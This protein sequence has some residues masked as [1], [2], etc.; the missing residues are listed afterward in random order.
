M[1][2]QIEQE[3]FKSCAE[4]PA[5]K[6]FKQKTLR[7]HRKLEQKFMQMRMAKKQEETGTVYGK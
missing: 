2:E 6:I 3:Q 5:M 4:N 7:D 1:L